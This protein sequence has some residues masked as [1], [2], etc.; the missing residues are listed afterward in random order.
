MTM[1]EVANCVPVFGHH[2]QCCQWQFRTL[3]VESDSDLQL[4][5]KDYRS[6]I[7]TDCKN[8]KIFMS[9]SLK[10]NTRTNSVF[11]LNWRRLE[12]NIR[13]AFHLVLLVTVICVTKY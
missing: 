8:P 3:L 9:F 11:I 6:L 4:E 5:V 13:Q 12:W 7:L 1:W 10:P 2:C